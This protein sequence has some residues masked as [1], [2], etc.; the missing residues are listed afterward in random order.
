MLWDTQEHLDS[1]DEVKGEVLVDGQGLKDLE[2]A[3]ELG[4]ADGVCLEVNSLI[5]DALPHPSTGSVCFAGWE[6]QTCKSIAFIASPDK[7]RDV[8]CS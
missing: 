7:P 2:G 6:L 3:E 8:A 5:G 1:V 4:R